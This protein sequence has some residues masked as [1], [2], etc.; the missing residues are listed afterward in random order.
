MQ[1]PASLL[2]RHGGNGEIRSAELGLGGE[3]WGG[4][5]GGRG[6]AGG[7]GGLLPAWGC[8]KMRWVKRDERTVPSPPD[9]LHRRVAE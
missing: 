8:T 4:G 1:R 9:P 7:G 5:G 3:G 2:C 6:Q